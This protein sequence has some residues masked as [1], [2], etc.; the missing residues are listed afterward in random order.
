[1][2]FPRYR[3]VRSGGQGRGSKIIITAGTGLVLALIAAA[4]IAPD[5]TIRR[6]DAKP[7][8]TAPRPS[9]T[10]RARADQHP[11]GPRAERLAS[12]RERAI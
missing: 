1:M 6:R 4:G 7:G 10:R 2:I 11:L 5:I 12:R 3:M 9:G 8:S